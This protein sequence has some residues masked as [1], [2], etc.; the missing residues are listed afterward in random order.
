MLN[1]QRVSNTFCFPI[2]ISFPKGILFSVPLKSFNFKINN[3]D[4]TDIPKK[5][6]RVDIYALREDV[7]DIVSTRGGGISPGPSHSGEGL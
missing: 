2:K 3:Q 6:S 5:E 7:D 1:F 4:A